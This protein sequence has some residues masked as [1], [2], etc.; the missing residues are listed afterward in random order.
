MTLRIA[1][2]LIL[3]IFIACCGGR[4][5]APDGSQPGE[6]SSTDDGQVSHGVR[7]S[8]QT[9]VLCDFGSYDVSQFASIDLDNCEVL[10]A[11]GPRGALDFS[12]EAVCESAELDRARI[13]FGDELLAI[14]QEESL[15]LDAPNDTETRRTS[16]LV[17]EG[18]GAGPYTLR[19]P[20]DGGET[21]QVQEMI[22]YCRE[23]FERYSGTE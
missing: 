15:E 14:Y 18:D 3:A 7:Q 17:D 11:S 6:A 9:W 5:E 2:A 8:E 1:S 12:K 21:E 23:L 16:L 13:V 10:V 20:A 4:A 22:G 19:F